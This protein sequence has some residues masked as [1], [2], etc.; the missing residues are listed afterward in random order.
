MEDDGSAASGGTSRPTPATAP[1]IPAPAPVFYSHIPTNLSARL[2]AWSWVAGAGDAGDDADD[3]DGEAMDGNAGA[4]VDMG[5][6]AMDVSFVGGGAPWSTRTARLPPGTPGTGLRV[7]GRAAP[8]TSRRTPWSLAAPATLGGYRSEHARVARAMLEAVEGAGDGVASGAGGRGLATASRTPGGPGP[9]PLRGGPGTTPFHAPRFLLPTTPGT[10]LGRREALEGEEG[11]EDAAGAAPGSAAGP[12]GR[13]GRASGVTI[14]DVFQLGGGDSVRKGLT[15]HLE[16]MGQ[17]EEEEGEEGEVG[18][19]EGGPGY[20]ARGEYGGVGLGGPS[21]WRPQAAPASARTPGF[22]FRTSSG[23]GHAAY[24][25]PMTAL[26]AGSPFDTPGVGLTA[27]ALKPATGRGAAGGLDLS[28]GLGLGLSQQQQQQQQQQPTPFQE[29]KGPAPPSVQFGPPIS[30][31]GPGAGAGV[32]AGAA[33]LGLGAPG[34]GVP[35]YGGGV[36]LGDP[37]LRSPPPALF[38]RFSRASMASQGVAGR[39]SRV[40]MAV[41]VGGYGAPPP[42][43]AP[44][45]GAGTEAGVSGAT[46]GQAWLGADAF[47]SPPAAVFRGGVGPDG[48]ARRTSRMPGQL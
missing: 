36:A 32:G 37:G 15:P 8:S 18:E 28:L 39:A 4:V 23:A 26:A 21:P 35:G 7:E 24:T 47:Q 41:G 27:S 17:E 10:G 6:D 48:R 34:S 45:R 20:G 44:H 19:G 43:P 46:L 25:S 29:F 42:A 1:P 5:G 16:P 3:S 12:T 2:Q 40:S 30:L 13:S 11:L 38:S 33:T 31:V 14:V 9:T 22:G